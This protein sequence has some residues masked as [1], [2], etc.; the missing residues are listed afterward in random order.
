MEVI[1]RYIKAQGDT[2]FVKGIKV[3]REKVISHLLSVDDIIIFGYG[4]VKEENTIEWVLKM[5]CLAT[6][7]EIN[8][9]KYTSYFQ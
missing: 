3:E 4:M 9:Q 7:R 5:L 2:A 8:I 6:E 1:S